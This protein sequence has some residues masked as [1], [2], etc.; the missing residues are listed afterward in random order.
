MP[1]RHDLG[2]RVR[3]LTFDAL[4][5]NPNG[6]KATMPSVDPDSAVGCPLDDKARVKH[7]LRFALH[8]YL[9]PPPFALITFLF[10][11]SQTHKQAYIS[12]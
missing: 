2:E 5:V 10:S 12:P 1:L 3:R 4:R 7:G 11:V 6:S 8:K 9:P